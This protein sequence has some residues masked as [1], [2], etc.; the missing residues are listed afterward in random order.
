MKSVVP[1]LLRSL[2]AERVWCLKKESMYSCPLQNSRLR[3]GFEVLI[4]S[5][6]SHRKDAGI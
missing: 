6:L 2:M 1:S 3:E 4:D 5:H